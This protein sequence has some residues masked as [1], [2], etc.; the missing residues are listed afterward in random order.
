MYSG[1]RY[2]PLDIYAHHF[3]LLKDNIKEPKQYLSKFVKSFSG[4]NTLLI[5]STGI[6]DTVLRID[7]REDGIIKFKIL[8]AP[9]S[10]Q[11]LPSEINIYIRDKA[12][13]QIYEATLTNAQAWVEYELRYQDASP[14][15]LSKEITIK[16]IDTYPEILNFNDYRGFRLNN[17]PLLL[18]FKQTSNIRFA[19]PPL[20]V[21]YYDM[22][23]FDLN[24]NY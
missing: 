2:T 5:L 4:G 6:T 10:I 21:P 16:Q 22:E 9:I 23:G 15:A 7:E 18:Y 3:N 11:P 1:D 12:T 19:A 24:Y 14:S 8:E 17:T 20:I 13:S